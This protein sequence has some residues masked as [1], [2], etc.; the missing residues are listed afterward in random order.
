M[1]NPFYAVF[2][3]PLA[4]SKRNTLKLNDL[5]RNRESLLQ[6]VVVNTTP[7]SSKLQGCLN[8]KKYGIN[9]FACLIPRRKKSFILGLGKFRSFYAQVVE[10]EKWSFFK[11]CVQK[12]FSPC[13]GLII[14]H[15]FSNCLWDITSIPYSWLAIPQWT[16]LYWFA[17]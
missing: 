6:S 8:K 17:I 10:Q 15:F 9:W 7:L 1:R 2:G 11:V 13:C 4:P 16:F 14:M 3:F 5:E 12:V